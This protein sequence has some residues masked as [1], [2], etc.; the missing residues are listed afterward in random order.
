MK[1]R[2]IRLLDTKG[3]EVDSSPWLT[4]GKTYHVLSIFID[5]EGQ[6]SYGIVSR[7][8]EDEW[9]GMGSYQA[10]CF[11]T[12]STVVPSNWRVWVH[13]SSAIGI[14]PLALQRPGFDED[15]PNH[16]PATYPVFVHEWE[17]ILKED[18]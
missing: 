10:E 12:I 15:F 7:E 6:R 14:S 3:N 8:R 2:C 18:P 4:I 11:E 5:R 16:Y 13:E 1:V 9:P 17:I